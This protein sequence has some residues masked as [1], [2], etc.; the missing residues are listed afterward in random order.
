MKTERTANFSSSSIHKL[1]K[2]GRGSARFSAPGLTYIKEKRMEMRLGRQL[3]GETNAKPTNWGTFIEGRVFNM[4]P[5]NF[6]LSSI[7]R[8]SHPAITNWTGSPD[9]TTSDIVGDIKC[10]YTLKSFCE[11]VDTFGDIEAFKELKPEYY[12][13]L[14]SNAIL[15]D[16]DKASIVVYVPYREELEE[17]REAANNVDGDQNKIAF[18]NWAGDDELPYLIAGNHY[19][20]LN[21]MEFDVPQEDKDLLTQRVVEAVELLNA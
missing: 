12:W 9:I 20:N 11:M 7:D 8:Y 3:T 18:L 14:V 4:L 1:I 21:I 16:V 2:E 13:Q 19:E 15:T 17:I 6:K 10:P 5:I